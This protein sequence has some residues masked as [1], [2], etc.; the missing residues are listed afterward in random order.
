M[1]N[2][3]LSTAF[4]IASAVVLEMTFVPAFRSRLRAGG[5]AP[6]ATAAGD[7]FLNGLAR[8]LQDHPA[9]T[10]IA[11]A[12]VIAL[13]AGGIAQITTGRSSRAYIP[14]GTARDQL[15]RIS[16]FFPG[17]MTFTVLFDGKPGMAKD[18]EVL[19]AMYRLQRRLEQDPA[20]ARTSSVADLVEY[21]NRVFDPQAEKGIPQD[22][23]LVAQL[24]FLS[25]SP[26]YERFVDRSFARAVVWAYLRTEDTRAIARLLSTVN[27][28]AAHNSL[29]D[30][31]RIR[32]AGGTGPLMFA[33]N[34]HAT[35]SKLL[36]ILVVLFAIYVISSLVLR[37]PL[38]GLFVVTPLVVTTVVNLGAL[39]W[40]RTPLDMVTA[41]SLAASVGIGADYAIY[42]LYR[43]REE[44]ARIPGDRE[45]LQAALRTS[46][47][48]VIFVAIA[49][50]A[51]FL[52]L[53]LS[54][55]PAFRLSGTLT[56]LAMLVSCATAITLMPA[57]VCLIRPAFVY[58]RRAHDGHELASELRA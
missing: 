15:N 52:P 54:S 10:I 3:G 31:A 7:R 19:D 8:M 29:G 47:R 5:A 39:G 40:S 50:S 18:P 25:Q 14:H 6:V 57:L 53:A 30:K 16:E 38:G 34:E 48:A 9:R 41:S 46:G 17:T 51:G 22:R 44:R 36:N 35:K 24:V 32:A 2:F 26:A 45:A 20:I 49:I 12:V 27:D 43:M 23:R 42:L 28:F 55:Y 1:S 4:G 13:A 21:V 37:T 56:P 58:G 33:L 11:F